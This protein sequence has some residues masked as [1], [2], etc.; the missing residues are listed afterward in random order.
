MELKSKRYKVK[1]DIKH[2]KKKENSIKYCITL[3]KIKQEIK[4]KHSRIKYLNKNYY[5]KL[6]NN[7]KI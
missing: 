7:I 6:K 1:S 4:L 3:N 5:P 2:R